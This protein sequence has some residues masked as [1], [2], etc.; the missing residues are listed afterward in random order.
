ME[1]LISSE[2]L[3]KII[4]DFS[5]Q[6]LANGRNPGIENQR[7]HYR[8]GIA[9]DWINHFKPQHIDY[10]KAHYNDVLLKLAYE[11]TADW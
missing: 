9:G 1:N 6:K 10:F 7:S 4:D 5:F 11:T 3:S 8:K 2:Q